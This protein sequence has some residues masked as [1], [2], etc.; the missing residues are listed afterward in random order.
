MPCLA[1]PEAGHSPMIDEPARFY[2]AIAEF[3]A[4]LGGSFPEVKLDCVELARDTLHKAAAEYAAA[5]A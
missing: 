5:H 3:V 1:F 4:Y 2:A